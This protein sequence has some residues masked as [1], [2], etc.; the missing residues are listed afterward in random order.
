MNERKKAIIE[1]HD[2]V[3]VQSM[4]DATKK[5]RLEDKLSMPLPAVLAKFDKESKGKNIYGHDIGGI[6]S[7]RDNAVEL[8]GKVWPK[9]SNIPVTPSNAGIFLIKMATGTKS[10]GMGPSQITFA[11]D[12]VD[13]RTGGYFRMMLEE[14]LLP[15][16]LDDNMYFGIRTLARHYE[17]TGSWL[18]AATLYNEG[19]LR[20]GITD[21]ARDFVRLMDIWAGRL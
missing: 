18:K 21:Y 3:N 6:F 15:W 2:F 5:V 11:S 1:S 10:N 14:F 16:D 12:L 8:Q 17:G 20:S 7:T 9:G 4:F 19:N 13:G